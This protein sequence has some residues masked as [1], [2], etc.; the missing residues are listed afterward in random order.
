PSF[1]AD[2][3]ETLEEIGMRA[4]AEFM[5]AGGREFVLIPCLNDH[6]SWVRAL[7][8]MITQAVNQRTAT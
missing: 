7:A 4:R 2:C 8:V 5:A 3:V 6:V 1:V